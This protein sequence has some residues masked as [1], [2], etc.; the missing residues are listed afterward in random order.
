MIISPEKNSFRISF[1]DSRSFHFY[2]EPENL[3]LKIREE[4]INNYPFCQILRR[5]NIKDLES[6]IKNGEET[7][8]FENPEY[9]KFEKI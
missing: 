4:R 5:H 6:A 2:F 7:G 3:N 9:L 1:S 8:V